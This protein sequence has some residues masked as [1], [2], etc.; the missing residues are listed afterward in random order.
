M[1]VNKELSVK[2]INSTLDIIPINSSQKQSRESITVQRLGLTCGS[3]PTYIH[4]LAVITTLK[5][6]CP[7]S[8]TRLGRQSFLLTPLDPAFTL[9]AKGWG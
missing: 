8:L 7:H 6:K 3:E 1:I 5:P 4:Q 2:P 9:P